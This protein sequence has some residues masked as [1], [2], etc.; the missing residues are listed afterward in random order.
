MAWMQQVVMLVVIHVIA[1]VVTVR[2]SLRMLGLAH[3]LA[4]TA[5][6]H[7]YAAGSRS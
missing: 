2:V 5:L 4:A 7:G 1:T 3:W 6:E